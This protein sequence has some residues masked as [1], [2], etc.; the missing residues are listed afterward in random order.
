M[1]TYY[2]GATRGWSSEWR[3]SSKRA[4]YTG[5]Y[6]GDDDDDDELDLIYGEYLNDPNREKELLREQQ[7]PP[8]QQIREW[9]KQ[10][11]SLFFL[12][13][14]S[15]LSNDSVKSF[16]NRFRC[17]F[18]DVEQEWKQ[19]VTEHN[20][21]RSQFI[22][23]C[24]DLKTRVPPV[25]KTELFRPIVDQNRN[26]IPYLQH[27]PRI[28]LDEIENSLR[29]IFH[30]ELV[31]DFKLPEIKSQNKNL[32]WV[33]ILTNWQEDGL[34]EPPIEFAKRIQKIDETTPGLFVDLEEK[35]DKNVDQY[36][37]LE[38]YLKD[39]SE[40][41]KSKLKSVIKQYWKTV[42]DIQSKFRTRIMGTVSHESKSLD[43]LLEKSNKSKKD[44][45]DVNAWLFYY[46][47]VVKE[48]GIADALVDTPIHI[49]DSMEKLWVKP[50]SGTTTSYTPPPL[51]QSENKKLA[52]PEHVHS[53][54][55]AEPETKPKQNEKKKDVEPAAKQP[56]SETESDTQTNVDDEEEDSGY[57]FD[58]NAP[59][60]GSAS[61]WSA[62]HGRRRGE[63]SHLHK[64]ESSA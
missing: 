37:V 13:Y 15:K 24:G 48:L 23:S 61:P 14:E 10:Q 1:S 11:F 35:L 41:N 60:D 9:A 36:D 4:K 27:F 59:D 63:P 22:K 33:Q 20:A 21:S 43:K 32:N 30:V 18:A 29:Y 16:E 2:S 26:K 7:K 53:K 19:I 57:E 17:K 40:T 8:I 12:P 34:L 5:G 6:Y 64:P 52:I 39:S 44:I 62:L 38:N 50:V 54:A 56:E 3:N 49:D 28:T 25:F 45:F 51:F 31:S 47:L 55:P 58:P 42:C 46:Y